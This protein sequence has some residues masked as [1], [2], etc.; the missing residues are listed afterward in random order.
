MNFI[1]V[2]PVWFAFIFN[3]FV[4]V[5][6]IPSFYIASCTWSFEP[7]LILNITVGYISIRCTCYCNRLLMNI[8]SRSSIHVTFSEVFFG[9]MMIASF[10]LFFW[11]LIGSYFAKENSFIGF[12]FAI[13]HLHNIFGYVKYHVEMERNGR[14]M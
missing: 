7:H 8:Y 3:L 4:F 6:T 1:D 9:W 10:P 14:F 5:L 13:G 2:F 11:V 12:C